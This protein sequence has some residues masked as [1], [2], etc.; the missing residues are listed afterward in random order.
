MNTRNYNKHNQTYEQFCNTYHRY[1]TTPR[2]LRDAYRG[3][4]YGAVITR[5]ERPGLFARLLSWVLR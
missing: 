5:F 3:A 4:D 1:T 2:T